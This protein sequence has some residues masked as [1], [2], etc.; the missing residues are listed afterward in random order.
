MVRQD[1]AGTAWLDWAWPGPMRRDLAGH[2]TADTARRGTA[3][4]TAKG[5]V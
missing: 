1:T 4:I 5:G 3:I 2:D